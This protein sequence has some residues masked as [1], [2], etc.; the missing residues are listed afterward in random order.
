MKKRFLPLL[1]VICLFLAL[2]CSCSKEKVQNT[3]NDPVMDYL[4]EYSYSE[5]AVCMVYEPV[6]DETDENGNPYY[7]IQYREITDLDGLLVS[8]NTLLLY[9]YSSMDNRGAAVTAAVEDIAQIYNGRFYV[10]MLDA[11]EYRSLLEKYDINAVPE[12]VLIRAGKADEVFGSSSYDYWTM[13]DVLLWLN[14]NGIA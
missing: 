1:T 6:E 4:G 10:L 13:N 8:G 11:V 2:L 5:S 7:G 14:N 12:F 3:D 9:F